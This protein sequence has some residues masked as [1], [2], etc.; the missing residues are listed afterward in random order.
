MKLQLSLIS[1]I[2]VLRWNSFEE[3]WMT[4]LL[5]KPSARKNRDYV[6]K[7]FHKLNLKDAISYVAEVS[8]TDR[9]AEVHFSHTFSCCVSEQ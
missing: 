8:V 2:F 7:V 6:F 9:E 3:K 1:L 4:S 5:M